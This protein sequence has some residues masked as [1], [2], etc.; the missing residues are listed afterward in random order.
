M[1]NTSK[2]IGLMAEHGYTREKI[3]SELG[4]TTVTLRRKMEAKK[5]DSDEMEKLIK[6]LDIENP[7]E[8]F[9]A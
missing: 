7:V 8:I 2:L 3:A 5:F 1:V 6:I 9:F 4:I